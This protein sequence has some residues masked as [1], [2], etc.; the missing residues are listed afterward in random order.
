[1]ASKQPLRKPVIVDKKAK[2]K[3]AAAAVHKGPCPPEFY[4]CQ[5]KP[6]NLPSGMLLK[7]LHAIVTN[8]PA[9]TQRHIAIIG[10]PPFY[11]FWVGPSDDSGTRH[12][13]AR[14]DSEGYRHI[15]VDTNPPLCNGLPME[16]APCHYSGD[17]IAVIPH[18]EKKEPVQVVISVNNWTTKDIT[19][20]S[21]GVKIEERIATE[22]DIR[23]C[24]FASRKGGGALSTASGGAAINRDGGTA[25]SSSGTIETFLVVNKPTT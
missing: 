2:R 16:L 25:S 17:P 7:G 9:T 10:G 24:T 15:V 12:H 11:H 21:S 5:C 20:S 8:C 14:A 18:D 13:V 23:R 19:L 3:A 1:M 4:A 6:D 22:A